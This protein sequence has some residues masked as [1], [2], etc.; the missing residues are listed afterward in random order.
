MV[1]LLCL[2]LIL[3]ACSSSDLDQNLYETDE[4]TFA[5]PDNWKTM[6]QVWGDDAVSGQEY[7]DLGVNEIITIQ[8]PDGKGKGKVF[9]TV[10]SAQ[11]EPGENLET[12]ISSVYQSTSP[13]IEEA[14]QSNYDNGDLTGYEWVYKRP[15]GEPYWKF[16]DVWLEKDG[17]I[18]LLSFRSS[19][20]SF[21]SNMELSNTILKSF[22]LK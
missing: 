12:F 8:Y 18:Y 20:N 5:I 21:D 4:F 15:W 17:S 22:Q 9:F 6:Q 19:P 14:S 2:L 13:E 16:R 11:L 7:K 10:A 1:V 3:T